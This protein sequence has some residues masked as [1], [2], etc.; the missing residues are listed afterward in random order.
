MDES[1]LEVGK[2]FL[3]SYLKDRTIN[4]D[5]VIPW[6]NSWE[7]IVLHSL[8]VEGYVKKLLESENHELTQEEVIMT[9]LAAI[10]HDVGRV[11]QRQEHALLGRNIVQAW[12]KENE[13]VAK[14]IKDCDRLLYLIEKHSN[15][16]DGDADYALKILR[17][18]DILD[19]I[20]AMSIFMSSTTI[21]RSNPYF[22][23][24]LRDR[25]ESF[26]VNF[27]D[28]EFKLLNTETAKVILSEKKKFIVDFNKQLKEELYGTENFG[29]VNIEDYFHHLA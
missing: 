21:D 24:L 1:I 27:C 22:F 18:A 20:G 19:E 16:E 23:K 7:F 10:L 3:V 15:K 12:L 17:D 25:V 14:N 26:E 11:H 2:R 4:Y 28:D 8:R 5:C 9:H 6:R 29:E 13:T